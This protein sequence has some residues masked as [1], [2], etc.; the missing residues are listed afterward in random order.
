MIYTQQG[1]C[2]FSVS[3]PCFKFYNINRHK[4]IIEVLKLMAASVIPNGISFQANVWWLKFQL[5]FVR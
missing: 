3:Y 2:F 1:F 5:A 4:K